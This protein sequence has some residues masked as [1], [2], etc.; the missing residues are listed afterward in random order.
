MKRVFLATFVTGVLFIRASGANDL[1]TIMDRQRVD[2]GS[3]RSSAYCSPDSKVKVVDTSALLDKP[4]LEKMKLFG[5]EVIARFYGYTD[6]NRPPD[7]NKVGTFQSNKVIT[8][9]EVNMLRLPGLHMASIAVFQ[10][11]SQTEATFSNW[12]VR[13]TADANR[14]LTLARQLGQPASTTIYF[15]ADGDFVNDT[16]RSC[17]KPDKGAG[18]C[19]REISAYFSVVSNLMHK[20]G[21]DVGVYGSGAACKL[22]T[23]SGDVKFCWLD[24]STGHSGRQFGLTS[25]KTVLRQLAEARSSSEQNECGRA[26]DFS[27][28]RAKD[29]GQF[30]YH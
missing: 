4:F 28:V 6:A 30:F 12:K 27:E 8:S 23:E 11:L 26:I 15:G 25:S 24:F 1:T 3:D 20:A 22:L 18:N 21:Y 5:V 19:S 2:F 10:Y 14:A 16:D 7:G 29:F 17:V 9:A 13:A